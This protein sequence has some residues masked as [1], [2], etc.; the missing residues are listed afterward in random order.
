MMITTAKCRE[1]YGFRRDAS[2]RALV[3]HDNEQEVVGLIRELRERGFSAYAIARWLGKHGIP[4]RAALTWSSNAILRIFGRLDARSDGDPRVVL[5]TLRD[6]PRC[7]WCGVDLEV[8]GTPYCR[9]CRHR[10]DTP[11]FRCDCPTCKADQ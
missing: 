6:A 5:A 11:R 4:P 9:R 2:T 1:P 3:P 10:S 8:A 7:N